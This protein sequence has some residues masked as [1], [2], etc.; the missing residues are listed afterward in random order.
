MA[1]LFKNLDRLSAL[2]AHLFGSRGLCA[3]N[4]GGRTGCDRLSGMRLRPSKGSAGGAFS[5]QQSPERRIQARLMAV[6][7]E[8]WL[9]GMS[10]RNA[11]KSM[12]EVDSAG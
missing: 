1:G 5:A 12:G 4:Q 6:V 3:L 10:G 9:L 2:F 7:K 8:V 11:G